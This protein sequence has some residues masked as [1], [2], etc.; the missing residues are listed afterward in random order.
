MIEISFPLIFS[1]SIKLKESIDLPLK[2][3]EPLFITCFEFNRLIIE[4]AVI[5]FPLPDYP[6]IPKISFFF[7]SK[8]MFFKIETPEIEI[9]RFFTERNLEGSNLK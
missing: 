4:S 8:E 3:I 5:D 2:L 9:Q 7:N 6:T 1:K